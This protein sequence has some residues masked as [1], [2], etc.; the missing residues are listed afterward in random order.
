[1]DATLQHRLFVLGV[2]VLGVL[3]DVPEL[4]RLLDALGDLAASLGGENIELVFEPLQAFRSEDDVLR[5]VRL[6]RGFG[7]WAR[8]HKTPL[9]SGEISCRALQQAQQ[10]SEGRRRAPDPARRPPRTRDARARAGLAAGR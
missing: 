7:G 3:A 1:G 8:P 9:G 4:S 2:V 6:D 5:H 10:Y